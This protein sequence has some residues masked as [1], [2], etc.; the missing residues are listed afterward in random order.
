LLNTEIDN[1]D[2]ALLAMTQ[3]NKQQS[4]SCTVATS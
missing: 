4:T 1:N 2:N 3:V